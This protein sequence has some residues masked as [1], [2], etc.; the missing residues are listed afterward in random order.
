MGLGLC[1]G[2]CVKAEIS[3]VQVVNVAPSGFSVLWNHPALHNPGIDV[4]KDSA[5]TISA[6]GEVGVEVYPLHTGNPLAVQGYERRRNWAA[7][8][9]KTRTSGMAMVHVF[10][11]QPDTTYY[12]RVRSTSVTGDEEVW[13]LAAPL[14][15]VKTALANT[16]VVGPPQLL[17]TLQGSLLEGSLVTLST[18]NAPYPLAAVVGDGVDTNQVYFNLADFLARDGAANAQLEGVQEL[19]VRYHRPPLDAMASPLAISFGTNLVVAR[20]EQKSW[21]LDFTDCALG[22]SVVYAGQSTSLPVYLWSYASLTGVVAAIEAPQA[23]FPV[24]NITPGAVETVAVAWTGPNRLQVRLSPRSNQLFTNQVVAARLEFQ[25]AGQQASAVVPLTVVDL[26]AIRPGGT[27]VE[28]RSAQNGRIVVVGE[29]PV[30][31]ALPVD[32]GNRSLLLYGQAGVRYGIE[33]TPSLSAGLAWTATLWVSMTN[34]V[35][36]IDGL[37]PTDSDRF[38]RA[39]RE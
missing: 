13:P 25:A 16:F 21:I 27:A 29:Q 31:E 22:E 38:Y 17:L 4:Y 11:C 3:G 37:T 24:V 35:Q 6:Q 2:I 14:P 34:I 1:P 28:S 9:E 30:L 7:I 18:T 36:R 19:L 15:L 26:Q 5:G 12:F 32:P 10:G 20:A 33:S 23:R 8:R 39:K